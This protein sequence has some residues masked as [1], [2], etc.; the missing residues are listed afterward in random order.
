MGR[1]REEE[2]G[3]AMAVESPLEPPVRS[4][5]SAGAGERVTVLRILFDS[6]RWHCAERGV[7]EGSQVRWQSQSAGVLEVEASSGRVVACES[8]FARFIQVTAEGGPGPVPANVA[9]GRGEES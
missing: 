7:A 1:D 9:G 3:L 6:L 2:A 5:A 4:L 8:R